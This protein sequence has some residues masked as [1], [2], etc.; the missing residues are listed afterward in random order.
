MSGALH[1]HTLE[2]IAE[3]RDD[4][5]LLLEGLDCLRVGLTLCDA[6]QRVVYAN[7]HFGYLFRVLQ[8]AE[9]ASGESA[10]GE[11]VVGQTLRD[12]LLRL[13]ASGEL[14]GTRPLDAPEAWVQDIAAFLSKGDWHPFDLRLSDGRWIELKNRPVKS[15]GFIC[16][17]TDV[18]ALR[19]S[20]MRLEDAVDTT[21]DAFAFW[22]QADRLHLCNERFR[23][24]HRLGETQSGK[25]LT[26]LGLL[27]R[28]V[29]NGP[30]QV[31]MRTE[32]WIKE[33]RRKHRLP[34]AQ[35]L[36]Q[37]Q[38]GRWF[39]LKE[40]RTRDGGTAM[41]L[42]DITDVKQKERE[43]IERSDTLRKTLRELQDS[44]ERFEAQADYVRDLV[45]QLDDAQGAAER[46][47]ATITA[48]LRTMSH[49]LRTPMTAII[50]FSDVLLQE[51]C[52]PL[53]DPTYTDYVSQIRMS[54]DKLLTL[55]NQLLDIAK[56]AA[57]RYELHAEALSVR[58]ILETV[59]ERTGHSARRKSVSLRVNVGDGLPRLW[60]DSSALEKVLVN[61]VD[62]AV[63]FT[64]PGGTIS[65]SASTSETSGW[66]ALSVT[67]TGTGIAPDDLERVVR[68]F[69]QVHTELSAHRDGAGLGLTIAK[70]LCE[71]QQGRLTLSSE[72]GK[73]TT[74][75]LVLPTPEASSDAEAKN[76]RA[77]A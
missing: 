68:P 7:A 4:I 65:L 70:A 8:D 16:L 33:R 77:I 32:A 43:L 74:A 47:D 17:W 58:D 9:S 50:G 52:G 44:R 53:G 2:R 56:A 46:A 11:S 27:E 30:F 5:G 69:E 37:H 49:E 1:T 35:E 48:F 25:S 57:G 51:P 14:A 12:V 10:V 67:D 40:R 20:H 3:V 28:L 39:L 36:L 23:Q 18:T 61:L 66:I 60:G 6:D 15:G 31:P 41:V 24:L 21:A 75:T 29:E 45:T 42:S 19:Q 64:A 34:L 73:G 38:D 22:D 26:Y 59:V 54:G 62:N 72:L 13:S 63:K 71:L 55:I 76:E